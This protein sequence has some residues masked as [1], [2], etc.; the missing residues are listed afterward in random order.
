[1]PNVKI[2]VI[3]NEDDAFAACD[4]GADALG[5]VFAIEAKARGRYI[6]PDAACRIVQKLPPFI[7]TVAVCVNDP[8]PRLIDY[9]SFVD[10]VQLCG[11][12]QPEDYQAIA[13][14]A[15]KVFHAGPDFDIE[16]AKAHPAAALRFAVRSRSKA[17][18][19]SQ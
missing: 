12:E 6:D 17:S 8:L 15:I 9:L 2:C 11:E 10:R 18:N 14:K 7:C 3:T 19:R 1:M 4:A 16:K 13:A 5:F